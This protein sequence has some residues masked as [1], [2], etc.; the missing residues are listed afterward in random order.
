MT[1]RKVKTLVPEPS[2]KGLQRAKSE[3]LRIKAF[4][5]IEE[6]VHYEVTQ[7]EC[8]TSTKKWVKDFSGWDVT[9]DQIRKLPDTY[10]VPFAKHGWKAIRLGYMPVHIKMS[11][12]KYMLPLYVRADEL[13]SKMR[14]EPP[15]HPKVSSLKPDEDLSP[16]KVK[17]WIAVWKKYLTKNKI[18]I[19]SKD[20]K[21]R[22]QYQ[23]AKTYV[24]NMQTYLRTGVWL[25]SWCGENRDQRMADVC[26]AKAY[27]E[28]GTV[29][30][31]DGVF[32]PDLGMIWKNN[33][34][35]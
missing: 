20:P 34:N 8:I 21:L 32:Y 14:Y 19:D 27:Y 25:D 33:Q 9:P 29:K 13:H 1:K 23:S 7:K 16:A 6:F 28:D 3:E 30:R 22:M 4:E 26:I 15:V 5:Q 10:L 31:T 11:L 24:H 12:E 17:E 35:S 18:Y 2:W